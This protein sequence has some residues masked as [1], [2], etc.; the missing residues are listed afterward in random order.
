MMR[1][2]GRDLDALHIWMKIYNGEYTDESFPGIDAL[3]DL[4]R[5]TEDPHVIY[6]SLSILFRDSPE[7]TYNSV[8][9]RPNGFLDVE[10]VL[11]ILSEHSEDYR[12]RYLEFIVLNGSGVCLT[13]CI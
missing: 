5:K 8:I 7:E 10:K 11:D 9:S 4:F 13:L 3:F 1:S 6:E 12:I 2:H